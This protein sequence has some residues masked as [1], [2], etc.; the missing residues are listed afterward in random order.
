MLKPN[1][2]LA[3]NSKIA[4]WEEYSFQNLQKLFYQFQAK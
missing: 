2:N 4:F 3:E 1:S